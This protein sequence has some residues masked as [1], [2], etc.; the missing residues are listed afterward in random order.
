MNLQRLK[1]AERDFFGLYPGGWED[2]EMQPLIKRHN[3]EKIYALANAS[4]SEPMFE[5]PTQIVESMAKLISRSSMIS[6]FEKPKFRD[7]AQNITPTE[8]K[9]LSRGLRDFLYGDQPRGFEEMV[10][11]LALGKLAKWSLVTACPVYLRPN[12]EV[13]VKPT[14]AKGIIEHYEVKGLVYHSTP[15]FEFYKGYRDL[16]AEMK[17]HVSPKIS[18]QGNAAF[19]GFLM[20]SLDNG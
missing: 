16:I 9:R 7:F 1:E 10:D 2:P 6:L 8:Q 4:F 3:P 11:V 18:E 13:F 14:T 20:M 12:E 17:R 5:S 19:T 15:T